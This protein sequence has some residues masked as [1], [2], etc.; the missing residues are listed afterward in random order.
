MV[1]D[2]KALFLTLMTGAALLAPASARTQ[3][4]VDLAE[5]ATRIIRSLPPIDFSKYGAPTPQ[6][7][8]ERRLDPVA[9]TLGLAPDG[10]EGLGVLRKVENGQTGLATLHTDQRA[11]GISVWGSDITLTARPG[12]APRR[13]S[14]IILKGLAGKVARQRPR[15]GADTARQIALKASGI[16]EEPPQKAPFAVD[17]Q[18]GKPRLVFYAPE[19][20]R[21]RLCW[22][23]VLDG[24]IDG[25]PARPHML[26]D[27]MTGKVLLEYDDLKSVSARGI[28]GNPK[29][30]CYRYGQRGG[31]PELPAKRLKNGMCALASEHVVTWNCHQQG[32]LNK[33]TLHT[34]ACPENI[35]KERINEG[36]SPVN[37]AHFFGLLTYRLYT[38]WYGIKPIKQKLN[39]LVHY[40]KNLENAYWMDRYQAMFFGDGKSSFY[41]LVAL[42][43]TAHEISHG[44]TS[45]HSGL[46]YKGQSGAIN[47]AFSDMAGEAVEYFFRVNYMKKAG[48]VVVAKKKPSP[49]AVPKQKPKS[50]PKPE[51]TAG[52]DPNAILRSAPPP[53]GGRDAGNINALLSGGGGG[54]APYSG[55]TAQGSQAYGLA[56]PATP[57][58]NEQ[59]RSARQAAPRPAPA[60]AAQSSVF[61]RFLPDYRIG[62]DITRKKPA[63]RYFENPEKDGF[64]IG[65]ARD[66][67][68]LVQKCLNKAQGKM[69]RAQSCIVHTA[70]GVFNRAFY[71]LSVTPGWSTREAFAVFLLANRQYWGKSETFKSAARKA[72]E[73]AGDLKLDRN[74]VAAAFRKTGVL[75]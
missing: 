29:T 58:E 38:E 68:A 42:D 3:E 44:F 7:R 71:L 67:R 33:C 62:A 64:S 1:L 19:N 40:K 69:N 55:G 73:A 30:G 5:Q 34:F 6:G 53:Y 47:E 70:S 41:P 12:E 4:R 65:H 17:A 13:V 18:A 31:L 22:E 14:G 39:M 63:L 23:V 48:P 10:G 27:A 51:R 54:D 28:G 52:L 43:V 45:Q 20:R 56:P 9:R 15:F 2:H 26:I 46:I 72:V 21:P 49:P 61:R 24:S 11:Y 32:N 35:E 25:R 59:P 74:A 66:Y 50:R 36:C 57:P 37:D 8:M 60:K 75:D 16:T